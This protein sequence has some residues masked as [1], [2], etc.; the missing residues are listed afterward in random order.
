[1]LRLNRIRP[2]GRA[3]RRN[4]RSS[5]VNVRPDSPEMKARGGG[6]GKVP[7]ATGGGALLLAS[8]LSDSGALPAGAD[9]G[10][11]VDRIAVREDARAAAARAAGVSSGAG[12][13]AFA[14][15][16]LA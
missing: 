11:G 14:A 7:C 10:G 3:S 16:A 9:A 4:A 6:G 2:H 13:A 5:A 12:A 1:M 15:A 8:G